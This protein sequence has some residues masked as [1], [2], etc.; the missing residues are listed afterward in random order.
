[1]EEGVLIES[2][3]DKPVAPP[4]G[5]VREQLAPETNNYLLV[6]GMLVIG[7]VVSYFDLKQG[8]G[9]LMALFGALLTKY[10]SNSQSGGGRPPQ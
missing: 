4:A 3:L 1:M 2:K 8:L 6:G 9:L 10:N 7:A 5:G